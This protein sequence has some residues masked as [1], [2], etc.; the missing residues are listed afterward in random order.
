MAPYL[1]DALLPAVRAGGLATML[2]AYHPCRLPLAWVAAQLG[3]GEDQEEEVAEF[4]HAR[5]VVVDWRERE[6]DTR[7]TRT[8]QQQQAA[9]TAARGAR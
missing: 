9:A 2:A 6:V 4:L 8:R 3:W 1:M 7:A 5:G